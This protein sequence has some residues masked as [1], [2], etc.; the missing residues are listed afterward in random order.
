M[1]NSLS[2]VLRHH[3]CE[4]IVRCNDFFCTFA[5]PKKTTT[6]LHCL[7][8]TQ[9]YQTFAHE[10]QQWWHYF[11]YLFIHSCSSAC[12]E[13]YTILEP[14][15]HGDIKFD[16][17]HCW[18]KYADC[19]WLCQEVQNVLMHYIYILQKAWLQKF[20]W[21]SFPFEDSQIYEIPMHVNLY[22][23]W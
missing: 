21:I 7:V 14:R 15:M 5:Q 2:E 11:L 17:H 19:W 16:C 18:D 9:R 12:W 4:T 6:E 1:F 8:K 22:T 3:Q 13:F 23:G 20:C 10:S